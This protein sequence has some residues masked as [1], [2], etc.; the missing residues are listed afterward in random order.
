MTACVYG[1]IGKACYLK[2]NHQNW[3]IDMK[4]LSLIIA[5]L[6]AAVFAQNGNL[7]IKLEKDKPSVINLPMTRVQITATA[8][9]LV[10]EFTCE[11]PNMDFVRKKY[12]KSQWDVFG[13]ENVEFFFSPFGGT[14]NYRLLIN[15]S[16]NMVVAFMGDPKWRNSRII[17]DVK[18]NDSSWAAT[19]K[20]PYSALE[21]D[22]I[23]PNAPKN[24]KPLRQGKSWRANF[25]RTRRASGKAEHFVWDKDADLGAK[26][27]GRLLFP[28][29]IAAAF[30]HVAI[31]ALAVSEPDDDGKAVCT[32]S[33]TAFSDFSGEAQ[34][35]LFVDKD[36]TCIH[37][38]PLAMK[39]D[40]SKPFS[41]PIELPEHSGV[42][43]LVM[44]IVG[45]D[46]KPVR[47]SR[48]IQI[49][50]PWME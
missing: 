43:K 16:K 13:G 37:K 14:P 39:S 50:N 12:A 10:A 47:T 34:F 26:G 31:N 49:A 29:D 4:K 2:P 41:V 46:A 20:V 3:R 17:G 5:L 40:E 1:K 42:F 35:H 25:S 44:E 7:T 28:D 27:N 21:D 36:A 45:K 32:G 18:M 15:P 30:S 38:I 6:A 9:E 22:D 19:I 33:I 24:R 11:E 48:D 8:S 23:R